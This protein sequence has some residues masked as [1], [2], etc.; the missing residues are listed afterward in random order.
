MGQ[1]VDD[2]DGLAR[3]E[4]VLE[5]IRAAQ[6]QMR[7]QTIPQLETLV[8]TVASA[9]FGVA[10]P[11]LRPK[12]LEALSVLDGFCLRVGG[13]VESGGLVL[14]LRDN[15]HGWWRLRDLILEPD[16]A[17]AKTTP[18]VRATWRGAAAVAYAD[19]EGE[20]TAAID[21]VARALASVAEEL[22]GA[23][24]DALAFY[25][26]LLS[27]VILT[28]GWLAAAIVAAEDPVTWPTAVSALVVAIASAGTLV[29]VLANGRDQLGLRATTLKKLYQD[30]HAD[31][32][33]PGGRWPS[34]ATYAYQDGSATDGDPSRWVAVRPEPDPDPVLD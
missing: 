25:I 9:Y 17:F 28:A 20:Q 7:S 31:P 21:A 34:S 18:A 22:A 13:L 10:G 24:R 12:L 16:N 5:Q 27:V 23:R 14:R 15:E 8:V 4:Q 1:I 26:T 2:D 33:F 3:Y 32:P 29:P 11:L 6:E 30:L 19:V